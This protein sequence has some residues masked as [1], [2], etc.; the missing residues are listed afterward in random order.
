MAGR[1]LIKELVLCWR[2]TPDP[3]GAS[4]GC[5]FLRPRRAPLAPPQCHRRAALQDLCGPT[6]GCSRPRADGCG[7]HSTGECCV[8]LWGSPCSLIR[9]F[10]DWHGVVPSAFAFTV[11]R[12]PDM[13]HTVL[14]M[15][16]CLGQR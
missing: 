6:D 4:P 12:C 7:P 11:S 9:P 3:F 8:H 13:Q 1:E 10:L 15:F 16:W 14:S 2:W 5:R